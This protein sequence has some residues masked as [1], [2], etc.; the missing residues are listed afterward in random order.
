LDFVDP[1]P[2]YID[3]SLGTSLDIL[4]PL[5]DFDLF[6]QSSTGLPVDMGIPFDD[7]LNH[8]QSDSYASTLH[9]PSTYTQHLIT[10]SPDIL[11]YSPALPNDN[12]L[13]D[14]YN[15]LPNQ[16]DSAQTTSKQSSPHVPYMR[17]SPSSSS[18]S[19]RSPPSNKSKDPLG[20]SSNTAVQKRTLNTQAARRYRQRKVDLVTGLEAELKETRDERDGLKER[21][22]RLEGELAVLRSLVG[23]GI[24]KT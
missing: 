19:D 3:L 17:S 11:N 2:P 15:P 8:D 6:P 23:K 14:L 10:T 20:P 24:E 5:I 16:S 9:T 13:S 22:A 7:I 1:L 4:D 12:F 21:V 18:S